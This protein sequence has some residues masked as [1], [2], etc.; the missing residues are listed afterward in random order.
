MR[1]RP[2]GA[3]RA[4]HDPRR[5]RRARRRSSATASRRSGSSTTCGCPTCARSASPIPKAEGIDTP[6]VRRSARSSRSGSAPRERAGDRDAVQGRHRHA[7]ADVRR[8]RRAA[9][10]VRAY[11]R[12]HLLH[13]SRKV[14]HVP[15]PD[16]ERHRR[17]DR[18]GARPRRRGASPSGEPHEFIQQD[19]ETD[20]DFIWRLAERMRASSSSSRTARRTF[21]KPR[22]RRARSSSSGPKTLRSFSPRVTAVQQVDV[23]QRL[24]A[25]DPKTKQAIE[26]ER[27]LDPEQIAQIG[28]DRDDGR[29][30]RSRTTDGARR[31]RAGQ[32]RKAE[33]QGARAGAARQA[34]QRLHRRRGRARGNPKIKA[35]AKVKVTGVGQ[36]FSGT[37]RVASSPRT[38]CAAAQLQTTFANSPSHTILGARR[39]RRQRAAARFGS[40]LVLGVVTNNNDPESM[41]RV[42]VQIPRARRRGRGRV[43]AH[44]GVSAGKERGLL[45]LPVVGEEV[46]VGFEHGDT[47][48]PYVLGSLFNGKDQPGDELLQD[49]NGSFALQSDQKIYTESKKTFTI[50]SGRQT[51]RRDLRQRQRE[52]QARL[53]ERDHRPGLAQG[54]PGVRRSRARASASRA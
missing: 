42:R 44:R 39:R 33:G 11:D 19:N 54:D 1:R 30:A 20:W 8:R 29:R 32:E 3:R 15:E 49:K 28:V 36:K 31:H 13:R 14:A 37:Y 35:G 2:P 52:G 27:D 18:Q 40:S 5:R 34:R 45:M 7:R 24:L 4:L 12:S 6:A 9:L 10:I 17:E 16:L 22:P 41:G 51:D 48:R 50:K 43:G 53:E 46:L 38:C 25:H 21:R 23:G 47:T 26:V